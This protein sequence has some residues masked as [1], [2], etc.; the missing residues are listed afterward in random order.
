MN[1]RQNTPDLGAENFSS[2]SLELEL[3]EAEEQYQLRQH[4]FKSFIED[5]NVSNRWTTDRNQE[6]NKLLDRLSAAN[7]RLLELKK[8]LGQI[9]QNS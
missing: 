5:K 4:E 1:L 6:R 3:A 2:N 9:S 8:A 7:H